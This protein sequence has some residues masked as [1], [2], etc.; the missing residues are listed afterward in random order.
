MN[1][2]LVCTV[3]L[4]IL[5]RAVIQGQSVVSLEPK[6]S[7]LEKEDLT[8]LREKVADQGKI[9]DFQQKLMEETRTQVT[10]VAET[11]QKEVK[12]YAQVVKVSCD[13]A[14]APQ[15]VRKVV[16]QIKDSDDRSRNLMIYGLVEED[17]EK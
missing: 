3:S 14:L 12:S 13:N 8:L 16:K 10:S 15:Q 11:V 9:I 7:S 5:E 1:K 17:E 4:D 2:I 6:I